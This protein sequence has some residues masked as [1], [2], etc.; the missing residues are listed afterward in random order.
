MSLL[1]ILACPY[2]KVQVKRED[3]E[4]T[5]HVCGRRYPIVRGVPVMLLDGQDYH[6]THEQ[7]LPTIDVYAPW[8]HR[9]ILQ[10]MTDAQIVVDVGSGNMALDDPCIIRMDVTLTP[11][12]DVVADLHALPFLPGSVDYIF[13]LAVFEHLRQPFV[14]AQ[15]I[16]AAL[17]PG[18]YAY[19]ECNFV[20]PYHG[21]PHHYF[22][23]SIQGMQQVFAQFVELRSGVAP[24][25]TP[26]FAL[27]Q[28]ISSYWQGF[29]P[30]NRREVRFA[31]QLQ[32]ILAHPLY[33]YDARFSTEATAR[34]A[35]GTYF[36]GMKCLQGHEL[37]LPEIILDIYRSSVDLQAR[38]P[39]PERIYQ[40]D[41]LMYWAL[42]E[43][44]RTYPGINDFFDN[45]AVFSKYLVPRPFKRPAVRSWP[46]IPE[47][48][49]T[50]IVDERTGSLTHYLVQKA[51]AHYR[52]GGFTQLWR[53][54]W[55]F[56]KRQFP[57]R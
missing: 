31:Q 13:A 5:C 8:L 50:W 28:V 19:A 18:G 21:Y 52:N 43:G 30:R 53:E 38:F 54:S 48:G 27:Q 49:T 9:M 37:L 51:R 24:Y 15:K 29:I 14:A 57:A 25:Q 22:N 34:V 55:A 16:Y 47:L 11:H 20:Y 39:H 56:L 4:L 10:S 33:H 44:R 7:E 6:V 35:A 40:P 42:T 32:A 17:K 41:N 12:T 3:D 23:A 46:A 2:C 26:G 45:L 1:E 36:L